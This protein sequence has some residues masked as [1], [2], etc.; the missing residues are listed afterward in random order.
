M[1]NTLPERKVEKI[2][3]AS[4]DVLS[5]DRLCIRDIASL[6]GQ[7]GATAEAV[8]YAILHFRELERCKN[9]ALVEMRG[10]FEASLSLSPGARKDVAW[11]VSHLAHQKRYVQPLPV[12]LTIYTDAS[13]SGWGA[14]CGSISTSGYWLEQE[15]L[16]ADINV[17]EL[18]AAKFALFSFEK[19]INHAVSDGVLCDRHPH[20][21]LRLM[22]DNTT[23]I[24]YIN[25]FGGTRSRKCHQLSFE[26]WTW[27]EARGIWL[28][29]AHVPGVHNQD[30]DLLSRKKDDNKEW[31]LSPPMFQSVVKHFGCPTI[32]LFASRTNK[33][34]SV[35]VSWHPDPDS[36]AIDAFT[37]SWLP[38]FPY[39][40]PPFSKVGDVLRK[41][42]EERIPEAV[43]IAPLWHTQGWYPIALSMLID[44]PLVF[45]A[46]KENLYLPHRPGEVHPLYPSLHMVAMKL[47]GVPS[48]ATD[49][50]LAQKESSQDRGDRT[51]GR[52]TRR[53]LPNGKAFVLR[54]TLIPFIQL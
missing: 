40:F 5:A 27:A 26:M 8:P 41:L 10:N 35:Y 13:K 1:T 20:T 42:R 50:L 15:W 30:A 22:L 12:A 2:L 32:D 47:S 48:R 33:K 54:G 49:F 43:L 24:A 51:R 9:A 44:C 6:L 21:H 53:F 34:L 14:T 23:A 16:D 4:R 46:A 31:A 36:V 17:L 37:F 7:Y 28:S 52:G 3:A 45:Q 29:A 19:E 18:T 11:W 25:H 39:C 38:Y